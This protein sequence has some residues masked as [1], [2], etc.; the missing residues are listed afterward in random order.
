M[1]DTA[2]LADMGGKVLYAVGCVYYNGI[3]G[4]PYWGDICAKWANGSFHA[5]D[6]KKRNYVN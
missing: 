5:S 4:A 1:K 2:D 6:S 3:D